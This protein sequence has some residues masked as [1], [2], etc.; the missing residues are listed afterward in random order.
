MVDR[1]RPLEP[2]EIADSRSDLRRAADMVGGVLARTAG[3]AK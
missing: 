3:R 2:V 1:G